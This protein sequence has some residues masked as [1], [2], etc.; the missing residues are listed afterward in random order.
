MAQQTQTS[1]RVPSS[2]GGTSAQ[3]LAT[4]QLLEAL[5]TY[6]ETS[7]P[8]ETQSLISYLQSM[9]SASPATKNK[10]TPLHLAIRCAR[11]SV[12]PLILDHRPNDLNA[13]DTTGA[14]PLHL[15]CALGRSDIVAVL[16]SQLEVDDSIKD[17]EGKT[18]LEKAKNGEVAR[19]I[20]TSRN[21]FNQTYLELLSTYVTSGES[22]PLLAWIKRNRSRCIQYSAKVPSGSRGTTIMHEGTVC[23]SSKHRSNLML[24]ASCKEERHAATRTMPG[25]RSRCLG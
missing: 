19:L 9:P 4:M 7:S 8:Q 25:E 12:V 11:V 18:C 14:T 22:G 2:D 23:V 17:D 15:A 3:A 24:Y 10:P 13:R 5:R 1:P 21:Q 6:S 20:Q 16:L